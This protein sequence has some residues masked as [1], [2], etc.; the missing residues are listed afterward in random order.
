MSYNGVPKKHMVKG[1]IHKVPA[2]ERQLDQAWYLPHFPILR[3][4]KSTTKVRIVFDASVGSQGLSL[5]DT[6]LQGPRL[7]NDLVKVLIRFRQH[8]VVI[9]CDISE[10][11][12][13]VLLEQG[14]R[15]F[16]RLLW[17]NMNNRTSPVVYEFTR[18]V[19]RVNCSLFLAQYVSQRHAKD[20]MQEFPL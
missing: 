1:Y 8:P 5:N 12:L 18:S 11:Y 3:P 13:Q 7:Q 6:I 14:D 20:H 4:D 16:H 2:E 15:S 17:Q 10:M 9:I 19:F